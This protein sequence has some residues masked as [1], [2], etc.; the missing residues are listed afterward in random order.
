MIS[1]IATLEQNDQSTDQTSQTNAETNGGPIPV[2]QI[3]GCGQR[4]RTYHQVEIRQTFVYRFGHPHIASLIISNQDT[5]VRF[6]YEIV[7]R[8]HPDRAKF[9]ALWVERVL[10]VSCD[11]M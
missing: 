3:H 6:R 11:W 10:S 8:P 4:Y 7:Q 1:M 9:E 2:I 5:I